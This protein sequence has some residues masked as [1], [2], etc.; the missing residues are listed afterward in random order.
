M[1][2]GRERDVTPYSYYCA[3][4]MKADYS[5]ALIPDH[6]CQICG[7]TTVPNP[8]KEMLRHILDEFKPII[9]EFNSNEKD[10]HKNT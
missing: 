9:D 2:N 7:R 4:C 3:K 8:E 6:K 10:I 1:A 5:A